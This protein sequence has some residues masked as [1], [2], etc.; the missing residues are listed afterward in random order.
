MRHKGLSLV[1][2]GLTF[3]G[4]GHAGTIAL[5]LQGRNSEL[6]YLHD[7]KAVTHKDADT[8]RV[9]SFDVQEKLPPMTTVEQESSFF[10]P[11]LVVNLWESQYKSQL[12]AAQIG[13][14]YQAFMREQLLEL[15]PV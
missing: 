1:F 2:M 8:I 13:N 9:A 10:L 6:M 11:L 4:C 12:G 3:A 7:S 15:L 14:D 5:E